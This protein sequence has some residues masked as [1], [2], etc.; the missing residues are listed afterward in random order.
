MRIAICMSKCQLAF[1][2]VGFCNL[3]GVFY[4]NLVNLAIEFASTE[5]YR[6]TNMC[7][8]DVQM[9]KKELLGPNKAFGP[10][11]IRLAQ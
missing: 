7:I 10:I 6:G 9:T 11:I 5:E 3:K 8:Q 2:F 4:I 1:E